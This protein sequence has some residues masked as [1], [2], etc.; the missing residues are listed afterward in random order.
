VTCILAARDPKLG[1]EAAEKLKQEGKAVEFHQLD[2][3]SQESVDAFT[4]HLESR[5][6][7]DILV[8]NAG[9]AYKGDIFGPDEAQN[10]LN[11]N[12][13]GTV[14]LTEKLLPLLKNRPQ[15][16]R[17]VI[18]S[19][20]AGALKQVSS[21]MQKKVTDV[22]ITTEQIF[23]LAQD[24]VEGIKKGDHKERGWS[25][26]MYG[27]SK[28]LLTSYTFSLARRMEKEGTN[29]AVNAICPGYVNT[30]MTSGKGHKT[31]A[32]GADTPVWLALHPSPSPNG[33][34]FAERQVHEW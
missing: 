13:Y 1:T 30:D 31:P 8:N 33:K 29:I 18:V 15:G 34:F 11:T 16:G 22:N 28:L 10:T 14:R 23:A 6:G 25:N 5:G 3:T 2:I 27:I 4:K 21:E 17:V 9:M 12:L 7:I 24:F 19:S 20:R 32:E 26:S